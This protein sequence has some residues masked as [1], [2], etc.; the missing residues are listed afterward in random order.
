MFSF[1]FG[2]GGLLGPDSHAGGTHSIAAFCKA[3]K[4]AVAGRIVRDRRTG[5]PDE[6]TKGRGTIGTDCQILRRR[7]RCSASRGHRIGRAYL[8]IIYG[9]GLASGIRGYHDSAG[10]ADIGDRDCE[11]ANQIA[12]CWHIDT[13][14]I[15]GGRQCNNVGRSR[16]RGAEGQRV[17]TQRVFG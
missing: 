9:Q 4:D 17:Q 11:Y 1:I 12:C 2:S 7:P 10:I 13:A 5:A 8:D 16:C 14:R 3:D 6:N 15:A